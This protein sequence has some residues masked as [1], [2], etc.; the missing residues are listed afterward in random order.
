MP[1]TPIYIYLFGAGVLLLVVSMT[2]LIK[3]MFRRFTQLQESTTQL[4]NS[5]ADISER[6]TS[7]E[8][9]LR[10]RHREL[11]GI[12]AEFS[13]RD[14]RV[15]PNGIDYNEAIKQASGGS[16]A[17]SLRDKIGLSD[18]EA[19]LLVAVYGPEKQY[20]TSSRDEA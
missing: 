15:V 1:E 7:L 17:D 2:W 9:G 18:T 6:L 3:A 5:M 4:A 11:E 10:R 12:R 20:R 14:S 19:E 16:D 8:Q 13:L